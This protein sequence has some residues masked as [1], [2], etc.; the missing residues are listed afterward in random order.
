[1]LQ[2]TLALETDQ[3]I[4][5]TVSTYTG[6]KSVELSCNGVPEDATAIEWFI[7]VSSE[8]VKILT[9]YHTIP[10]KSP[11][12]Y[13]YSRDKYDISEIVKTSLVV[14]NVELLDNDL[15]KCSS[16]GGSLDYKYTISLKIMGKLQLV[17]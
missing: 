15:F 10:G 1:M 12:W 9:F 11:K 14:K 8:W 7:K 16:R 3:I 5:D 17:V 13:N 4:N 6:A 2:T